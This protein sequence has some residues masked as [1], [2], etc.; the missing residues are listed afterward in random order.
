MF[1]LY[2][3][4]AFCNFLL[5]LLAIILICYLK[6]IPFPYKICFCRLVIILIF[7]MNQIVNKYSNIKYK[8]IS[9]FSK[10]IFLIF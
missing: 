7:I 4:L 1:N 10:I 2:L 3:Y 8:Y 5:N 6:N 9:C